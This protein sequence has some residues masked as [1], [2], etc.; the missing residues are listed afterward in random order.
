M[1]NRFEQVLADKYDNY[2]YPFFWQHGESHDLLLEEMRRIREC[3]IGAVCIEARPHP[4]YLGEHWWSDMDLIMEEARKYK[5]KVWLLDDDR[6]P[7]GHSSGAFSDG[8][9]RHANLFLANW[10]TDVLGP[11]DNG[12]MLVKALLPEDAELVAVVACPRVSPENTGL[13]LKKCF[14]L[15][16]N[17]RSGWLRW[18]VPQGLWR[19]FVFYATHHGNGK[20]D[21]F[22]ILDSESVRILIDTVYKPHFERYG[23]DFGRTFMGFFSD[24]PE[25]ANLPGYDFQAR[26]G[27]DMPYIPWSRELK[28]RLECRWG[29]SFSSYLPALWYDAGENTGKIRYSY[30]DEATR[31]LKAAFSDQ[32]S[33]WCGEHGVIHVGHIIEDDNSHGRLGCS[34]GHYFRSLS[35]MGMAGIDVVLLQVMPGH[36]GTYHQWVASDRDGEFFHYGL[37]KLGS[38]LA[39]IDAKKQGNSMCEIFGAF[40]WQEGISLMK[41]L[42]DHMLCRGINH[43]VPHAFSPKAFPDKDCPPH[44]YARGNHPQYR[45]FGSLMGYM[46]RISH[47][48][49]GGRYPAEVAVLYHADSEWAGDAML[50]QKPLRKLMERQIACDIVP[51]DL[52][53][54]DNPYGMTFDGEIHVARQSYKALVVPAC[55]YLP[56]N[57]EQFV[58]KA[59]EAGFPVFLVDSAPR[60]LCEMGGNEADLPNALGRALVV[61]LDELAEAVAKRIKPAVSVSSCCP[62]LR[63]FSYLND[64]GL[65]VYCFNESAG[66]SVDTAITARLPEH[67]DNAVAYD[68]YQNEAYRLAIGLEG[69]V[70]EIPLRL[71]PGEPFFIIFT[72]GRCDFPAYEPVIEA[73]KTL[74]G[75]WTIACSRIHDYPDFTWLESCPAGKE[76]PDLTDWAAENAFCGVLQYKTFVEGTEGK[77]AVLK[78]TGSPDAAEVFVSGRS[79]GKRIGPPW[80]FDIFLRDGKNEI[81]IELSTTPVWSVGDGWSALTVLP[82]LGLQNK[83]LVYYFG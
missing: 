10:R 47:L 74:D 33:G 39:H 37:A 60:R 2:I 14:D 57:V 50:F 53:R 46:N 59:V 56:E 12:A 66:A 41:W 52:F 61:P 38:S 44:F 19:I 6:F 23:G 77:N 62:D 20:L 48:L 82:P 9:N 58:Q 27:K 67:F 17:I 25:F 30:M 7:T 76:F 5:M 36:T 70:A 45:F 69:D 15:S 8:T 1:D 81:C 68:A 80:C 75:E 54:P 71:E 28:E 34:T 83:P 18:S 72:K 26:L 11:V 49:S 24:E 3:G 79:A 22:N 16:G 32:I 73:G 31:Q 65:A 55:E 35:G 13:A 63:T 4:D 78:L 21:Y 40:G 64:F 29:A 51:A 43:F 42:A